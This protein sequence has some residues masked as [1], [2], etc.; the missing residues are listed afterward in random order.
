M[1]NYMNYKKQKEVKIDKDTYQMLN[2]FMSSAKRVL[3]DIPK[4][5]SMVKTLE[6]YTK[7]FRTTQRENIQLKKEVNR[8]ELENEEI[9]KYADVIFKLKEGNIEVDEN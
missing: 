6:E 7:T 2:K 4:T 3:E 1:V 5:Q 9:K 8:L